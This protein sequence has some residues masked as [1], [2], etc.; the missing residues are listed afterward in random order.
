M[1]KLSHVSLAVGTVVTS[2]SISQAAD[3]PNWRG[4]HYDGISRETGLL[5]SWPEKKGPKLLWEGKLTGGYS[6]LVVAGGR[7][8]TQ[9]KDKKE[10]PPRTDHPN[11]APPRWANRCGSTATRAITPIIRASTRGS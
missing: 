1:V 8:I 4:P 2:F 6:S 3:W 9:T 7:V 11:S 10:E 5:K